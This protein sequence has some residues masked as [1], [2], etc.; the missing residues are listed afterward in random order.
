MLSLVWK[1]KEPRLLARPGGGS[2]RLTSGDRAVVEQLG[3]ALL[4]QSRGSRA[5]GV[6]SGGETGGGG[7][8]D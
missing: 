2:L 1:P 5:Q 8:G 4:D 6:D 7:V 3:S